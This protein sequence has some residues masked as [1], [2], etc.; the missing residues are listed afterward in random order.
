MTSVPDDAKVAK[1][2]GHEITAREVRDMLK[3]MPD[4]FVQQVY[5][6]NPQYAVQQMYMMR[7]LAE[8]AGRQKVDE[9]PDIK[10]Q[11]DIARNNILA[12]AMLSYEQN[13]FTPTKQAVADYYSRNQAKF[14][15]AN[16]RIVSVTY[17]AAGGIASADPKS[18]SM[19][20]Q[21]KQALQAQVNAADR[22]E[23][24]A[25]VRAKEAAD[26]LRGG[27]KFEDVFAAYSDDPAFKAANGAAV[28]NQSSPQSKG[29]KDSV[30][31]MKPGDV[32]DPLK[33]NAAY[34]VVVMSEKTTQPQSEVELSINQDLRQEHMRAWFDEVS[35]RFNPEVENAQFFTQPAPGTAPAK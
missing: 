32:S 30:L 29:F 9:D 6:T 22:T 8:E 21:M 10:A 20:D 34:Y 14:A 16:V 15:Q 24:Q 23:A 27:A 35:K 28:V 17:K 26:K 18:G 12:G 4:Q 19:A 3:V 5:N 33:Q 1:V 2:D 11:L 31:A 25:L 13:H 7:F